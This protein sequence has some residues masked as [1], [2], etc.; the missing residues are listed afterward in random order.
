MSGRPSIVIAGGGTG[1]HLFPGLALADA[2]RPHQIDITFVGTARGLEAKA[3]PAAG[4]RLELIDVAGL[5]GKG[6][7]ATARSLLRLP[8]SLVQS[9]RLLHRLHPQAVVGVGGYAS[10]PLVLL[11]ALLGI[12]TLVLEQNSVPGLTNKILGR[13]VR[14]VIIA[15]PDA[16]RFFPAAKV[17]P[18]GN[19]IRATVLT[20]APTPATT[21]T[22]TEPVPIRVLVLG[23]SQ[24]AQAVNQLVS[25]AVAHW[26][27]GSDGRAQLTRQLRLRHQ[28]GPS[29]YQ[30]ILDRYRS[31]GLGPELVQVEAFI[32]DI[33]RA[34]ADCDLM[35]GRAGATTLA[36]LT[37][38]GRP[39]LL[40][41]FPQAADDH[42]TGNARWLVAAGA[43]EL[44]PQATTSAAALAER[45]QALTADPQR[46]AT[47]AAASRRLGRPDAAQTIAN[48]VLLTAGIA[49]AAPST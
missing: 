36:E 21:A 47:M 38:I 14:Q 26:L 28:T 22:T 23:G 2:L 19:P 12:P 3:V 37:A 44:L 4:Y 6:V 27:K 5:K 29:D 20:P 43:A 48:Q 41:P 46:L 7:A 31:L 42:Q 39:A 10:G 8:L 33:G 13:L 49:H 16:A 34:Y 30:A 24:G 17:L 35:V 45:I 25:A 18:L 11:A 15:F 40:I 1:G 9:L 32:T